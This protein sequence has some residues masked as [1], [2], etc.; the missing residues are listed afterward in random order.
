MRTTK[1]TFGLIFAA[2]PVLYCGGL[3]L[4]LNNVR[5]AFGG[6][7]DGAMAPTMLGLGAIGLIFLVLFLWKVRRMAAPPA[8][9]RTGGGPTN[10]P[11]E[12]KS[13]FDPDAAIA[14]YLARR[15]SG[16]DG[17]AP[18]SASPGGGRPVRQAA[19]GRK[20]V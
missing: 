17:S 12:E 16:A 20:T 18:P 13:D 5:G 10:G 6:L 3:L 9:P 11:E 19:F 7:L 1:S 14:R 15:E 2:L 4:Y 8:P